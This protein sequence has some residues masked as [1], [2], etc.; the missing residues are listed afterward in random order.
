MASDWISYFGYGSLVNRDT[1]PADE[2]AHAARLRGW[3]R[4]WEHRI[5]DSS[6]RRRCTSLS[7][8]PDTGSANSTI[9]GMV[10]RM[11]R[12]HLRQL[13]EREAGYERLELPAAQFDLPEH[14][15][16]DS[17]LVYRSKPENRKA[18]DQDHP[19][20]QSY[21]DCV[22]AGYHQNFD[23]TGMHAFVSST[24]GWEGAIF[25]DR[26]APRYPRWVEVAV[27]RQMQFDAVVQQYQA[28]A[29]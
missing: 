15:E 1:R 16:V 10:V 8:E 19:V 5:A 6:S 14:L 4:V 29:S 17:V 18:A 2:V 28:L 13:D 27:E 21:I 23:E 24:R 26:D 7:I 12:S 22:L 25:N 20:L 9:E 11:P 3:Q